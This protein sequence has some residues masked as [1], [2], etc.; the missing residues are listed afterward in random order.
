MVDGEAGAPSQGEDFGVDETGQYIGVAEP[1]GGIIG[2]AQDFSKVPNDP[3][4]QG[5]ADTQTCS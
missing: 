1:S 2:Q 3:D 4:D 5:G